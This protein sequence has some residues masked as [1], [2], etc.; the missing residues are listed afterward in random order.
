MILTPFLFTAQVKY[1]CEVLGAEDADGNPVDVWGSYFAHPVDWYTPLFAIRGYMGLLR[2]DVENAVLMTVRKHVFIAN[3][4]TAAVGIKASIHDLIGPDIETEVL[5]LNAEGEQNIEE[6]L[7]FHI[8]RFVIEDIILAGVAKDK[9]V[10]KQAERSLAALNADIAKTNA[11]GE[12]KA[13][14]IKA[15]ADAERE[16]VVGTARAKVIEI[17]G[18]ARGLATE[19][20]AQAYA[21]PGGK[22]A[23]RVA[24]V[25]A[26][27][28]QVQVVGGNA[29]P[30]LRP[31]K[32]TPT[33]SQA[34]SKS[35]PDQSKKGDQK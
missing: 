28:G 1:S 17:Q 10:E 12:A 6:K 16:V 5:K 19:A 26:Y 13:T 7:G 21:K 24:E 8:S 15:E 14:V 22:E 18:K 34:D 31:P 27:G 23:A 3:K 11:E 32:V 9:I 2:A 4:G 25:Q 33:P 20:V 30:I 29:M 35:K